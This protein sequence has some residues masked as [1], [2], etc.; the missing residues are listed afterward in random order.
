MGFELWTPNLLLSLLIM[1]GIADIHFD[2][3]QGLIQ[4]VYRRKLK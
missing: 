2:R 1:G 3:K 4:T